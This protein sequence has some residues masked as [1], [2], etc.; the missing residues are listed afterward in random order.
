MED[1]KTIQDDCNL[2]KPIAEAWLQSDAPHQVP[3]GEALKRL[4]DYV[5]TCERAKRDAAEIKWETP[6]GAIVG[7]MTGSGML[8]ATAPAFT[9]VGIGGDVA[10]VGKIVPT[11]AHDGIGSAKPF[12]EAQKETFETAKAK[13]KK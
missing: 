9:G 12:A 2:L 6:P 5:E 13:P 8:T 4:I 11:I 3:G 1:N 10:E 7:D